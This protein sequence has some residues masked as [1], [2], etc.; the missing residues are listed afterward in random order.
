MYIVDS[1]CHLNFPD[2][3]E[4]FQE[5][6]KRA[7]QNDVKCML[8]ICT[9][10]SEFETVYHI[11]K[12]YPHIYA[13]VG[14]HPCEVEKEGIASI[15][16]LLEKTQLSKVIGIGETGLDYFHQPFDKIKQIE[17]FINHIKVA[18]ETG[19]P[20][21]VH[22]RDA[23]EDTVRILKEQFEQKP[24]KAI[25]HC[26]TGTEYLKNEVLALGFTISISGIVTFKNAKDLQQTIAQVPLELMLVE[27]DAPYLAPTPMRGKRNEPG[28]TKHT[29]ECLSKLLGIEA[30]KVAQITTDNFFKLFS[31]AQ[32]I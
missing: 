1:H 9:K 32:R 22:T 18:Q 15:K 5:M 21:I 17:N 16:E 7:L 23:E 3:Q 4:D 31:K 10:L 29:V 6:L 2:F 13:S 27:T 19:L 20:L 25:I 12:S 30:E 28:F 14:V 24:F 8:S 26:F 11:A